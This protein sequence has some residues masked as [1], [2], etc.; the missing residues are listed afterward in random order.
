MIDLAWLQVITSFLA[1]G[2][3][4]TFAG[5]TLIGWI[6]TKRQHDAEIRLLKD[7]IARAEAARLAEYNRMDREYARMVNAKDLA[8]A[9]AE[10]YAAQWRAYAREA[11]AG[12]EATGAKAAEAVEHVAAKLPPPDGGGG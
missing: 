6:I 12:L 11:V 5:L 7:E 4:L 3:L 9:Q 2:V 8:I 10:S 1:M